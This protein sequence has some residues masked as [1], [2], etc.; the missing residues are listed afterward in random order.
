MPV[1]LTDLTVASK[2]NY[3]PVFFGDALTGRG[4]KT[5]LLNEEKNPVPIDFSGMSDADAQDLLTAAEY[6]AADL[7]GCRKRKVSLSEAVIQYFPLEL[8]GR[9][10]SIPVTRR[11]PNPADMYPV[12]DVLQN[13]MIYMQP[14]VHA[15]RLSV[16][17]QTKAKEL[18]VCW[19]VRFWMLSHPQPETE[20]P[21][22]TTGN[23]SGNVFWFDY[24]TADLGVL[25]IFCQSVNTPF[26]S[27]RFPLGKHLNENLVR[28]AISQITLFDTVCAQV[29]FWKTD[30]IVNEA[31]CLFRNAAEYRKN[32]PVTQLKPS[33]MDEAMNWVYRILGTMDNWQVSLDSYWTIHRQLEQYFTDAERAQLCKAN[34]NLL[35][36]DTLKEL[37]N[38][39][40]SLNRVTAPAMTPELSAVL[41]NYS[42]DQRAIITSE[43]PLIL[44]QA[45]AGT[46]K[47]TTILGR[48]NYMLRSGIRPEDITVLSFTNA[49]ADHIREKCGDVHSMTIASMIHQIYAANF[50]N[51]ELSNI[52]TLANSIKIL[53]HG[54][55]MDTAKELRNLLRRMQKNDLNAT[56]AA[57]NTLIEQ[58]YDEV[59]DILNTV[60]QTSLELEI[61]ICYQKINQFKEPPEIT[62]KY[63]IVDEVQDNSI[64][65]FIYLVK[66]VEKH[67]ECL[68]I[69]GDG[70]QTLYEFRSSNPKALNI[71]EGSGIFTT[72]QLQI[73]YRS[74]QEILHLANQLLANIEAN[75]YANIRLQSNSLAMTSAQSFQDTVHMHYVYAPSAKSFNEDMEAIVA[76][77]VKPYIDQ[78]LKKKQ[79]VAFLAYTRRTISKLQDFLQKLYPGLNIVS[80][81]PKRSYNS[82]VFSDFINIYWDELQFAPGASIYDVI[83]NKLDYYVGVMLAARRASLKPIAEAFVQGWEN[84]NSYRIRAIEAQ[85]AAGV[86]PLDT[87]LNQIRDNMLAYEI[88]NNA[89]RQ[90]LLANKN[91]EEKLR[92]MQMGA[93]IILSTIHSAKGLE[94]ENTVVLYNDTPQMDEQDKRMYYVALTR[95]MNTEFVLAY[96][97]RMNADIVRAYDQVIADLT[98]DDPDGMN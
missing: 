14:A 46:G 95:A 57:V 61:I 9:D 2:N 44:V 8:D 17:N 19:R 36:C 50:P 51:Q 38:H 43:D 31:D 94:F 97:P 26:R 47:S 16:N 60:G 6:D 70:S 66:Y 55:Y 12:S 11:V 33:E 71:L 78:C 15:L 5:G 29:K 45:G 27:R 73:N 42:P 28:Q 30:D 74:K 92:N 22:L 10:D 84:K 4:K 13:R 20:V 75:Q 3:L 98:P 39:I 34:L 53:Y 72:Y 1:S 81:V 96:G 69:V 77:Q 25:T 35:L 93:N 90:S 91:K 76:A 41:K 64:F 32:H 37:N 67:R 7:I 85:V 89:V 68:M 40:S 87:A 48:I 18:T 63:L 54:P 21:E 49:A 65:E 52:D 88:D 62:S 23:R 79:Q 56:F 82:T 24:Y 80:L 83:V 59:M 58:H 86:L